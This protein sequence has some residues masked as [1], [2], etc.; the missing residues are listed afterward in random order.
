V[1]QQHLLQHHQQPK[2]QQVGASVF[3]C[4]NVQCTVGL[5][6]HLR[7]GCVGGGPQN[8]KMSW[9]V[10]ESISTVAAATTAASLPGLSRFSSDT[11]LAPQLLTFSINCLLVFL[12]FHL[13]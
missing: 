10:A 13:S 11:S 12:C 5:L 1:S 7:S 8:L 6:L 9:V 2:L 3:L 4:L